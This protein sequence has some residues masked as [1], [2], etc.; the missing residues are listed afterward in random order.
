[1]GDGV[2]INIW[3]RGRWAISIL[4]PQRLLSELYAVAHIGYLTRR[5]LSPLS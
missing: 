5:S 4:P 2:L 1:V 3:A